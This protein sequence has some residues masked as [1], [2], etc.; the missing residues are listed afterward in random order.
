M[1]NVTAANKSRAHCSPLPALGGTTR[2][3]GSFHAALSPGRRGHAELS[4]IEKRQMR[5]SIA[6][7]TQVARRRWQGNGGAYVPQARLRQWRLPRSPPPFFA[8]QG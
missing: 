3:A 6:C 7:D 1:K 8:P 2:R 5:A 4:G